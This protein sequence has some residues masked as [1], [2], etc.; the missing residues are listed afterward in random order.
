MALWTFVDQEL[1]QPGVVID[2]VVMRPAIYTGKDCNG[3]TTW[4]MYD[5][6]EQIVAWKLPDYKEP[7]FL[8]QYPLP[9]I[10]VP[11]PEAKEK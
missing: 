10:N 4:T 1:P 3:Y 7:F 5:E 8:G 6:H 2:V 11:L 9:S